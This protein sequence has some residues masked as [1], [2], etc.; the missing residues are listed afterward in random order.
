MSDFAVVIGY[1]FPGEDYKSVILDT[2]DDVE[3]MELLELQNNL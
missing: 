2:I 1:Q 3:L